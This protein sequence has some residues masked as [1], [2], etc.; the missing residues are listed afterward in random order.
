[1]PSFFGI[2]LAI[3]D[4]V[5]GSSGSL[6]YCVEKMVDASDGKSQTCR[7]GSNADQLLK[8]VVMMVKSFYY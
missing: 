8:G 2:R 5:I 7:R 4:I 3:L 1:V 6:D